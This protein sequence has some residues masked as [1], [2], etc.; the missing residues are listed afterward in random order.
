[1]GFFDKLMGGGTPE[2]PELDASSPAA[3]KLAGVKDK[4]AELAAEVKDPIE[5]VPADN[6]A[7]VFIGKPPKTFG[8]A[9]IENGEINNF[10]TLLEKK[11]AAPL[12]LEKLSNK[13]REAYVKDAPDEKFSIM[14]GDRKITV[15]PSD[16][17]AADVK[18]IIDHVA[19]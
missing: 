5:V 1:M 9:W 2:Y 19:K 7:Y 10:K 13:L 18:A 12:T 8:I 16:S 14:A 11:G 3:A 17:L 6:A 4:L 15:I